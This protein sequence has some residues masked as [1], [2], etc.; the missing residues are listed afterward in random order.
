MTA[1]A[2][3]APVRTRDRR[4]RRNDTRAALAF[5]TPS[6]AGLT[7]F[8]LFPSV[9][10]IATSLFHWPT[11]GDI[12]FAGLDNYAELF[13][14]RSDFGPALL[15]TVVFT[16]LIV[17]INLV[18]TVGVAFWVASSRFRQL[19]R[20]LFFIPVVTPSVATAIIWKLLYQPDGV[21]SWVAGMFGATPPNFLASPSSALLSVVVVI[22]WN[23]FGYNMLIFS[24]AIDQLPEDV[25]AAASLDGAGRWRTMFQ[26]KLPLMTPAIFFATTV[27]L[28]QSFQIFN[29]PYVMTAG[30]PGTST[31]TVVMNVYQTAF[32][33][34]QLGE[35]AAPAIVLFVLILVVTLVQWTGQKKWVQ[36]E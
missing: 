34:G 7:V 29:E 33:S 28:I 22:L 30:G 9:L 32:Q 1:L 17:P 24:A 3:R 12:T 6:A 23:G 5:L 27:T 26:M 10:A 2:E 8:I 31:I 16:L 15:N 14:A 21:L 20:V 35:A 36:Y 13:S 4:R 11:Y 25:L 19:Y 18:L